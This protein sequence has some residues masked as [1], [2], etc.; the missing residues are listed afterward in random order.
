VA[1]EGRSV[2]LRSMSVLV[3]F[4]FGKMRPSNTLLEPFTLLLS[5]GENPGRG[6][7]ALRV[8]SALQHRSHNYRCIISRRANKRIFCLTMPIGDTHRNR[9]EHSSDQCREFTGQNV[10]GNILKTR[11]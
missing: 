6:A 9:L 3:K 7:V 2:L 1:H 11:V 5:M 8:G 10:E 4:C